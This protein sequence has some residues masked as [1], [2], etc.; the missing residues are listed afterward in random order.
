MNKLRMKLTGIVVVFLTIMIMFIP[1]I[2][3]YAGEITVTFDN[4]VYEIEE[5]TDF[6]VGVNIKASGGIGYY[7]VEII[8]DSGRIDYTGGADAIKEDGVLILEGTGMG[9]SITYNL[10]FFSAH[11]GKAGIAVDNIEIYGDSSINFEPYILNNHSMATVTVDGTDILEYDFIGNYKEELSNR[12]VELENAEQEELVAQAEQLAQ[13]VSGNALGMITMNDGT[14]LYVVD[15][16]K[17]LPNNVNWNY[18]FTQ[19][20]YM[21]Q[22][23][24]YLTDTANN[25]QILYFMDEDRNGYPYAI[26]DGYAYPVS[27]IIT[28]NENKEYIYVTAMAAVNC[29]EA[30]SIEN[31]SASGMIYAINADG[32]GEF[33]R[34]SA[35]NQLYSLDGSAISGNAADN[36]SDDI[37]DNT[38]DNNSD[39]KSRNTII[40]IV[41][42]VIIFIV[43]QA[44][45]IHFIRKP[46]KKDSDDDVDILDLDDDDQYQ[47]QEY[48]DIQ[49]DTEQNET[50]G[51]SI[52]DEVE[53][54][55]EADK[56]QEAR[57][58]VSVADSLLYQE[59]ALIEE[60][61][62][63]VQNVTMKFTVSNTNASSIKEYLIQAVKKKV[64]I[65]E[66]VALDN[67]SFDAYKGEVIGIIGT[68]GSGKSTLLRII[69]GALNPTEGQV[70]VDE[71]KVQLLTL[72]TGFDMELT[73]RENVYL[74]G[75]LIGYSKE[76]LDEHYDEIVEFAELE[77]FMEAKVKTFSSGMVSRL[78]FAIAT[79]GDAAEILILDEVLS[80]GDEFFRK[81]SLARVQEMIHG[82]STVLM[83]SHGMGTIIE[84]CS[85]VVWIEKGKLQMVGDARVVCQKYKELEK[86]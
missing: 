13:T 78:G 79:I 25:I 2:E 53:K 41:A 86:A 7:H 30:V 10:K 76:F 19:G 3:S 43:A 60:P 29:P 9:D 1:A 55:I 5:N 73:A 11:S 58:K 56:K 69:S 46:D 54:S 39:I 64:K 70:L 40:F 32:V 38:S 33:Y 17:M 34:L 4:D 16:N 22:A 75:S 62:I 47:E 67:V 14:S 28:R 24:T 63:S 27:K 61:I 52:W 51:N 23:V 83:V 18:S 26:K 74:N 21:G 44:V 65:R 20:N 35:D 84:N 45:L 59:D 50:T 49:Q 81:K 37:S 85:K 15:H 12:E 72:G 48:E 8:Y 68:N 57:R 6:S 31:E 36:I 71:K 66:V 77:G 42:G 82:G 80:V